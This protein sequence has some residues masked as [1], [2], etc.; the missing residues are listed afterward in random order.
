M[1]TIGAINIG[2]RLHTGAFFKKIKSVRSGLGSLASGI[3]GFGGKVASLVSPLGAATAGLAGLAGIGGSLALGVKLAAEAETAEIAFTNLMSSGDRA[4]AFLAT[5]SKFAASTPFQLS[6]LRN[7]AQKLLSFGFS[8]DEAMAQIKTLGDVAAGSNTPIGELISIIGKAKAGG[9]FIQLGDLNMLAD[10]GVPIFALLSKQLGV[11]SAELK[12]MA[13]TGKLSLTDV[14][15]ALGTVTGANQMFE[16]AMVKQS[17]SISGL[18]STMK[19]NIAFVLTELG[20]LLISEFNFKGLIAGVTTFAQSTLATIQEWAPVIKASFGVVKQTLFTVGGMIKSIWDAV[21]EYWGPILSQFLPNFGS[22]FTSW[23]D[24]IFNVLV[25][26]EYGLKN[27][28]SVVE[29]VFLGAY[30][31]VVTFIESVKHIFS[32]WDK[33]LS[34]WLKYQV[35]RFKDFGNNIKEVTLWLASMG[36]RQMNLKYTLDIL[37]PQDMPERKLSSLEQGLK[38][39]IAQLDTDMGSGYSSFLEQR[40]K[41]LGML[42][43]PAEKAA[44][45]IEPPV[46]KGSM[47]SDIVG[48]AK[49]I[50]GTAGNLFNAGMDAMSKVNLPEATETK[51]ASAAYAGTAEARQAILK[52]QF[53]RDKKDPV[54]QNTATAN[55]WLQKIAEKV[56]QEEVLQ[57][58]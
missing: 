3:G 18:F 36:K 58:V 57:P 34:G 4:R 8:A 40:K 7:G 19:D 47:W 38:D 46:K 53:G 54:A 55:K 45:A 24:M 41:E 14:Q 56:G 37:Q 49:G 30:L 42:E 1:S 2:M 10:R 29:R 9:G 23:K 17:S 51:F 22:G 48:A 32:N 26:V 5:L 6:D 20:K 16:G 50:A 43:K 31:P 44:K 28:K 52:H 35:Q 15:T 12:K 27:W 33:L 21:S 13:S 39:R 25:A 11:T